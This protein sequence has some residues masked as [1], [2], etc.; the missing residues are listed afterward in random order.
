MTFAMARLTVVEMSRVFDAT[1]RGNMDRLSR[2]DYR[3]LEG[4]LAGCGL[5]WSDPDSA[6]GQLAILRATYEPFLDVLSQYL[7]LPLP[8]WLPCEELSE[9]QQ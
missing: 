8:S 9:S 6:E 5:A 2:E 3:K 7:L 4:A 1:P